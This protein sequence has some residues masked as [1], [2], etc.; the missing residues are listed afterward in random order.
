MS[1]GKKDV[2]KVESWLTE[3]LQT[4]VRKRTAGVSQERERSRDKAGD[5]GAGG[6]AV[7][8]GGPA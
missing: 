3:R 8:S 7:G 5:E 6:Q 4:Q 1:G 2:E